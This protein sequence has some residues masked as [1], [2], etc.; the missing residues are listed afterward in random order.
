[1]LLLRSQRHK[2][3]N[4]S[5]QYIVGNEPSAVNAVASNRHMPTG[6]EIYILFIYKYIYMY[7]GQIHTDIAA[8]TE[9]EWQVGCA[10]YFLLA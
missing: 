3:K 8:K 10:S 9:T 2:K 4:V 1:M 7:R 5:S 6:L